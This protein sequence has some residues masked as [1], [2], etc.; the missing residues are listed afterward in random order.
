MEGH[1]DPSSV[2]VRWAHSGAGAWVG[3]DVPRLREERERAEEAELAPG[4]TRARGAGARRRDESPDPARTCFE[5]DRDRILHGSAFRRLAGKTQ[6]FVSP[7]DHQRTRLTHALEVAQVAVAIARSCRLNVALTEAIALGHDCGHGPGGHASEDALSPYVVGGYDHATWGADVVL[8]PLNLCA[9]TLDGIRNHSWSRPAPATPE[10]EVVSWADRIAYV[11][12]DFEDAV[13]AG[14]V[15]PAMLPAVVRERAGQTRGAQLGAFIDGV[16][17]AVHG[18]GEVGMVEPLAEALAAFRACNYEWIY[19]RPASI[20]QGRAVSRVLRA[21]VEHFAD[22][23]H[24]LPGVTDVLG[25]GSD[26]ARRAAVTW[27]GGMT[28]RYAFGI[29]VAQLGWDPARLPTG[30]GSAAGGPSGCGPA[31]FGDEAGG[32]KPTWQAR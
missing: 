21:L 5:R 14:I 22:R 7:E 10:G 12:H 28:D 2:L 16:V 32:G 15:T 25:A 11:C 9:E 19:L 1:R 29:A 23:P 8:A 4:A 13:R 3:S 20:T 6:V 26:E 31:R 17:G 30:V 18:T 24:L 27:V